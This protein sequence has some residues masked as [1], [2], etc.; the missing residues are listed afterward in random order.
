[1]KNG[2]N[3]IRTDDLKCWKRPLYQLTLPQPLPIKHSY[4]GVHILV[5][6][7][8]RRSVFQGKSVIRP[9]AFRPT[10]GPSSGASTPTN[11][12]VVSS[13]RPPSTSSTSNAPSHFDYSGHNQIRAS[14]ATSMGPVPPPL[15]QPNYNSEGFAPGHPLVKDGRRHYGSKFNFLFKTCNGSNPIH[16]SFILWTIIL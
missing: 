4:R 1:M 3:W 14:P 2:A 12:Y 13:Y 15:P 10:P 7:I 16:L 11:G 8:K 9:I 6:G 5:S